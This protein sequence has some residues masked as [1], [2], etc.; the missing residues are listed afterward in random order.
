MD[1]ANLDKEDL[2][3]V[4]NYSPAQRL[5]I[6]APSQAFDVLVQGREG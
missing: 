5:G 1:A 2:E 4:P 6:A 3:F